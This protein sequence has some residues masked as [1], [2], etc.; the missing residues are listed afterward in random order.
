MSALAGLAD[1]VLDSQRIFRGVL[2]AMAHPGRIVDL[3]EPRQSPA[4]LCPATTSIC[5]TLVDLDTPIWLDAGARTPE[6]I[7]YLRFHCGCPVATEP[8]AARFAVVGEPW[9][10]PAL[11]LFDA[12]TDEYPDR[13]A[14]VI[15]QVESLVGGGGARLTG[16]GIDG[17]ARLEAVGLP[18]SFWDALER[19]GG[20]FPRGVDVILA[21]RHAITALP[22][23]TRARAH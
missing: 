4:A 17:E 6:A 19:N 5:L 20:R 1:P 2:D 16:P 13:S 3:P 8:G 12:G 14:T 11:D 9:R 21:A 10:M 15:V 22:R 18:A 7:D 23:S